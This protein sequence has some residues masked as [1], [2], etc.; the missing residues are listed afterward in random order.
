MK[1]IKLMQEQPAFHAR[2]AASNEEITAVENVLGLRF[3]QDYR[4]Y[5]ATFGAASFA[6]HELTGICK[7]DRLNVVT[8]T[9]EERNNMVVPA[10]WYV[11][12]QANIDGIVIWQNFNGEVFRTFPDTPPVRIADSLS[13]YIESI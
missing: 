1:I 6:G 4:E 7:S 2:S 10:D 11:L 9:M 5:V 13:E 8:V 12:E 3:A